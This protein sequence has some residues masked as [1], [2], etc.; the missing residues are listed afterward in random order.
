MIT[1]ISAMTADRVIGSG[2]GMPWDVPEEYQRYLDTVRGGVVAFGRKSYEIFGADLAD[3]TPV[4]VTRQPSI[5]SPGGDAVRC[6]GSLESALKIADSLPGETFVAGGAQIYEQ[7]IPLAEA[8]YLSTIHG[9]F[10]GDAYFPAFDESDW[11]VVRHERFPRY[12]FREYR[13]VTPRSRPS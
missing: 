4:V 1:I 7:A 11:R 3:A 2:D 10:A 5:E 13:R 9:D 12:D 8:M 6:A